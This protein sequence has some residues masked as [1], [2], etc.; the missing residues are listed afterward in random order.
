MQKYAI[1][2]IKQA[3]VKKFLKNY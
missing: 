3:Q 2:C 1:D